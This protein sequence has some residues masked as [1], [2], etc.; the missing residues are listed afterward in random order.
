MSGV[1]VAGTDGSAGAA[2]AVRWAADD[3]SRRGLRVHLVHAVPAGVSG[4]E[5]GERVLA[6]AA[7]VAAR[8]AGASA[9]TTE[10]A[11]GRP[12]EVLRERATGAAEVVVGSHGAGVAP[13]TLVGS[14]PLRVA[15]HV[16][17]AVVVAR[18]PQAPDSG[19][20]G[21][22][23]PYGIAFGDLGG[24]QVG[25]IVVGA[26]DERAGEA[27]EG[28]R[29]L[30]FAFE[31]ARLH[32]RPLLVVHARP[33]H[34]TTRRPPGRGPL[35]GTGAGG[36]SPEAQTVDVEEWH[37]EERLAGPRER[38]PDVTVTC[39]VTRCPPVP[40]LVAA[41]TRAALLVV[42]SRGVGPVGS[43]LLGSVSRSVLHHARCTVAVVR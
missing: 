27:G 8:Y 4:T 12:D 29:A 22:D 11:E 1:I 41:S 23:D 7:R 35:T 19:G 34:A 2:A 26:G 20:M 10:L 3:A 24:G 33:E 16:A 39:E 13:G 18:C 21:F 32:R 40:A 42:G 17:G 37:G 25:R 28:D 30:E 43:L 5:E 14:V 6:E 36:R 38:Y 15:G 9:V 31:Q